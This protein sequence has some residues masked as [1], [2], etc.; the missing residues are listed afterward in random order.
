KDEK[1]EKKKEETKKGREKKTKPIENAI[2]ELKGLAEADPKAALVHFAGCED[3]RK[4]VLARAQLRAGEKEKAE[5]T[6]KQAAD[7]AEGQALPW[8]AYTELLLE[9]GKRKEAEEAWRKVAPVLRQADPGLPP[10]KRLEEFAATVKIEL[11]EE[12]PTIVGIEKLGPLAWESPAAPSFTPQAGEQDPFKQ[13]N[14]GESGVVALFYLGSKCAHCVQ[15]LG[16]FAAMAED[17]KKAHLAIVA[18][19][20][21]TKEQMAQQQEKKGAELYPFPLKPDPSLH[22]FKAYRCYDDFEKTPL[23]GTFPITTD[24]AGQPR[25]RWQ[26]IS[27]D[28][29]MDAPFLLAECK[30]LLTLR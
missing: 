26:D 28:P 10:L 15:Q 21:E 9:L 22:L 5:K 20:S 14:C 7:A 16:K 19:S 24:K 17:F 4:E 6:A 27:Y 23:H 29:F 25:I 13:E 2:A 3:L 12:K 8:L 30:R 1:D 11:P 18:I